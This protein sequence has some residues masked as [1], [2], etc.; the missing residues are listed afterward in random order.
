MKTTEP[1]LPSMNE[2]LTRL[3]RRQRWL[4]VLGLTARGFFHGGLL[5]V[6]LAA[7]G[8]ASRA[9]WMHASPWWVLGCV[10]S[11]AA[12]GATIGLFRRMPALRLA[13]AMDQAAR[14]ED[15]FASAVQLSGHHR[16]QRARLVTEDALSV[17][18]GVPVQQALPWRLPREIKWL[19]LPAIALAVLFWLAPGARLDAQVIEEPEVTAEQWD[20]LHEDF[21]RRLDELPGPK[22]AEE[23]NIADRLEK[24]ATFL[25]NKP[26][27]KE[28]LARIAKLR[29][30]LEQRRRGLGTQNLSMRRAAS[31]VRSSRALREFASRLRQG[32]Y[33]KA[34]D[35]L[36]ALG[37]RLKQNA[38]QM[39]AADFEA[40]AADFDRLS[41]ELASH[42]S[43][44]K[45]CRN[46]S[47]AAGS[48]NRDKLADSLNKF[49]NR[50]RENADDLK[51]CDG[52]CRSCELLDDLKRR[53]S[54][55]KRGGSCKD[56]QCGQCAR[57]NGFV[58]RN[59]KKGGLKA[60]W[61]TADSWTGGG[62]NP[63]K[64][65]RLPAVAQTRERNGAST[66]YTVVSREERADSA[67][68]YKDLYA[69]MVQKA[70]ADLSLE[71]VP[72]AYREFL[73]RYFLAIRPQE[74]A[75]ASGAEE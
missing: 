5:A 41:S 47:K 57:C 24:L 34:A 73:R 60:G 68:D 14:G 22:T 50:L 40:V 71:T 8:A 72:I 59:G 46:C 12:V 44:G 55:C 4:W 38:R 42:E 54:Q 75:D 23:R 49:A 48:L 25:R 45:A 39:T 7:V 58:R 69:E 56:G 70:E 30:M 35:A 33:R 74:K 53:L 28:A 20:D 67:L 11:G 62:L 37:E 36:K 26:D 61:G 19:P 3:H 2:V 27:K 21:R 64:E 63:G 6:A 17:V 9:P 18:R 51:Q 65:N 15:R 29:E 32:D 31:S 66:S 1:S 13:R 16:R 52:L 43:L 10:L